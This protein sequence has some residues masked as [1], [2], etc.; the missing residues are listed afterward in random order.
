MSVHRLARLSMTIATATALATIA[1][2]GAADARQ[3]AGPPHVEIFSP[4]KNPVERVGTQ[5]V[6]GD[7]LTGAGVSAPLFLHPR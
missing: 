7:E 4:F 6:R 1:A 5:I 2:A 3:D